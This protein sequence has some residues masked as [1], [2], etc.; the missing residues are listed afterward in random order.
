MAS[1]C[2]WHKKAPQ[3]RESLKAVAQCSGNRGQMITGLLSPTHPFTKG[4]TEELCRFSWDGAKLLRPQLH[5][6][7]HREQVGDGGA[8]EI[9]DQQLNKQRHFHPSPKNSQCQ[10]HAIV[11][12]HSASDPGYS[13]TVALPHSEFPFQGQPEAENVCVNPTALSRFPP[14]GARCRR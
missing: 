1:Q 2:C 9:A 12:L 11:T 3:L 14:T 5:Q 7:L 4:L 10:S 13:H 8:T 6:M